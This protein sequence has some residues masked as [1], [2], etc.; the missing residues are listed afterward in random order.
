MLEEMDRTKICL[1]GDASKFT[2]LSNFLGG[3]T[4]GRV[5][6]AGIQAFRQRQYV[7]VA[8]WHLPSTLQRS[9]GFFK[10]I[11]KD[12]PQRTVSLRPVREACVLMASDAQADP[13]R[14]PSV[15]FLEIDTSQAARRAALVKC[16]SHC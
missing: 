10:L 1:P 11:F 3:G 13:G 4:W 16:R 14:M 12:V 7:D 8:P 9:V 2:G 5:A 6:R 15:G